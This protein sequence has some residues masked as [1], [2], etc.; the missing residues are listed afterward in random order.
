MQPPARREDARTFALSMAAFALIT[1][2]AY[3]SFVR[4][5][6]SFVWQYDGIDQHYPALY[7]FNRWIRGFLHAPGAGLP[8]W[9]SEIGMGADVFSTLGFY[10]IGDPFALLSLLF[11]M[12]QMEAAYNTMFLVRVMCTGAAS[13]W[14]LRTMGAKPLPALTGAVLYTFSGLIL[15]T[16]TMHPFFMNVAVFLPLMFVAIEWALRRKRPWMLV[17]VTF[18]SA[19]ANFYF[20]YLIVLLSLVYGVARYFELTPADERWRRLAPTAIRLVGLAAIGVALAAPTLVTSAMMI[21]NTARGQAVYSPQFLYSF[22]DYRTMITALVATNRSTNFSF[23]TF[24]MLGIIMV[25]VL[26]RRTKRYPA[27]KFLIVALAA[28]I[29]LPIFGYLFNG[30]TFPNFRYSFAL[31]LFLALATALVLSEDK[32]LG[33]NDLLAMAGGY[34][35]YAALLLLIAQPLGR[36]VLAPLIIGAGFL[37]L[38][39]FGVLWPHRTR[40]LQVAV[41]LLLVTNVA[42]NSALLFNP[43]YTNTLTTYVE[44]GEVQATYRKSAGSLARLLPQAGFYRVENS[45]WPDYNEA[46][47]DRFN[48]T[49][50]Y[51]SLMDGGLTRLKSDL[52]LESQRLYSFS[53]NGFNGRAIPTALFGTEYYLTRADESSATPFGFTRVLKRGTREAYRNQ[54]ALPLGFV[55]DSVMN[56]GAFDSLSTLERQSTMLVAAVVDTATAPA[57][58]RTLTATAPIEVP[59]SV[60][61]TEGLDFDPVARTVT[62]TDSDNMLV[63]G[64]PPVNDAELYVEITRFENTIVDPL[65][66]LKQRKDAPTRVELERAQSLTNS[67]IWPWTLHTYVESGGVQ[68]SLLWATPLSPYHWGEDTHLAHLGYQRSEATTVGIGW[69]AVGTTTYDS[70]RVLKVPMDGFPA[71]IEK[72]RSQA[73]TDIVVGTNTVSGTVTSD[74]G[75]LFLSIPMSKGWT[76]TIDGE[77]AAIHS[78]NSAF[79]GIEVPAGTHRIELRFVAPGIKLGLGIAAVGLVALLGLIGF[80]IVTARRAKIVISSG[81]E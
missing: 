63:L 46:M 2:V 11:P 9:S 29:V 30:F 69:E 49:S 45:E 19:A 40:A 36:A 16:A 23:M 42:V 75:L 39:A 70:L 48:G 12:S 22:T 47:V 13:L 31:G 37:A 72:L 66:R 14:Y 38:F 57:L 65:Q 67:M 53:F 56:R 35:G 79:M 21:G 25:P 17:L 71:A 5:G 58:P 50:F 61:E 80:G 78:A 52:G 10:V 54:Y 51:F 81:G 26:F 28:F 1:L 33:R 20:F 18:L 7:F 64:I 76:A 4:T 32:P 44:A 62:R 59:Y 41:L 68:R 27:L 43:R 8:L 77:P 60:V 3:W 15:F 55:Y 74:G 6:T 73:M 24:S 34:L